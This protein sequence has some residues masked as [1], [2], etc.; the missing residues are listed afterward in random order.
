[1]TETGLSK[2]QQQILEFIDAETRQPGYPPSVR[3][4]GTAVGLGLDGS[5]LVDAGDGPVAVRAGDVVHLRPI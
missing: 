5:L 3:E 2:R 4:I 1:M